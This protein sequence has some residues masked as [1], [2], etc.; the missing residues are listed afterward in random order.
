MLQY[1][2]FILAVAK[3]WE[4]T[5]STRNAVFWDVTPCGSCKNRRFVGTC[6][7]H[8]PG[9][10]NIRERGKV[11]DGVGYIYSTLDMEAVR[12]SETSVSTRHTQPHIPENGILHSHR[13]EN[14]KFYNPYPNHYGP[15][16]TWTNRSIAWRR[17]RA[18]YF[19]Y[20]NVKTD[21]KS[22]PVPSILWVSWTVFSVVNWLEREAHPHHRFVSRS[23]IPLLPH[24]SSWCS[25]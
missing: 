23:R 15:T 1:K 24:T 6:R 11:L 16:A 9:R 12:S 7:F 5:H 8:H 14:L 10:R 20:N 19:R 17:R 25:A 22:H 18:T 3:N 13:R 4:T 2:I 21:P